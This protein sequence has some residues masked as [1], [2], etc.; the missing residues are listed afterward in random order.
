M[1]TGFLVLAI[2]QILTL[3]YYR[4]TM[5]FPFWRNSADPTVATISV[6]KFF[7]DLVYA[8]KSMT[9]PL[10]PELKDAYLMSGYHRALAHTYSCRTQTCCQIGGAFLSM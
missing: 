2:S 3:K 4:D 1:W 5:Y 7:I 8:P 6:K 9:L 10:A